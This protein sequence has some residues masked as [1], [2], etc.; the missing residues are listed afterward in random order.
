[1]ERE[2]TS[3][4]AVRIPGSDIHYAPGIK[5]GNWVFLTGIEAVD[6][7]HGLIAAVRGNPDLPHHGLP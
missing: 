1:V 2:V 5:A 3:I 6:Y 4:G 7:E